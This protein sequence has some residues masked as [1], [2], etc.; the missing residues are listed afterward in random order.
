VLDG[1][2]SAGLDPLELLKVTLRTSDQRG[3]LFKLGTRQIP[4]AEGFILV[5]LYLIV[6]EED[7]GFVLNHSLLHNF[8]RVTGKQGDQPELKLGFLR[9]FLCCIYYL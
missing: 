3:E 5:V 8:L 1:E 6:E 9:L 4:Y 7:K 2:A